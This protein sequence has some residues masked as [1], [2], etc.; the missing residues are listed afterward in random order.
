M[1]I[2]TR[3]PS[4]PTPKPAPAASRIEAAR[5]KLSPV[6][7]TPT[8]PAGPIGEPAHY[9]DVPFALR[10]IAEGS[11]AYWDK[12]A[13]T[14][15]YYGWELP[16]ELEPYRSEL[17]SWE[18]LRED[19][20]NIERG[21]V[22]SELKVRPPDKEIT[23]RPHQLEGARAIYRAMKAG[24][25]GFL[26]ADDVGLGKTIETWKAI[27]HSEADTVLVVCPLAVIA[28][29]RRTIRW[30]GDGGKRVV[31]INYD[32]LKKLFEVPAQI[33]G[34]TTRMRKGRKVRTQKGIAKFGDVYEFDLVVWDESHRL[35][36]IASARA[37]L[38]ARIDAEADF[39]IW[40]SATAGQNPLE[41]AYLAP[42]LAES[43]GAKVRDLADYEKWCQSQGIGVMRGAFGKWTWRGNSEEP[44]ER[45][46]SDEDLDKV[47]EI[48]FG[49]ALPV[50]IRR[51]PTDI[52]GWPEINRILLP[53][54]L[55]G[56]DRLLYEQAWNEFRGALDLER[57]G[58]ADSKNAL[59]IRLRF[60]QKASLLRTG[61]TVDHAEELLSQGLQVAVSVAFRETLDIIREA[62]AKSGHAVSVIHG[63]LSAGERET[64]RL[65]FQNGRTQACI[66]TVEEGISLHQGEYNDVPRACVIHDVRWSA[67]QMKQ[68]EGRTHRDGKF[69]QVYWMVGDGTVEERLAS[70]VGRRVRSMSRM[71]GDTGT[72]REIESLL[73]AL[74]SGSSRKD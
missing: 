22:E 6:A 33:A 67:I 12:V 17:Y 10:G 42:L 31:V 44:T 27:L 2:A 43:T 28:H 71:Q 63:G 21:H 53:V 47:R 40:L 13:K 45:A 20:R 46:G 56:E 35:R 65:D 72:E 59:V 7:A 64:Q 58:S 32:R 34:K 73:M 1:P 37:K 36:N 62:L 48:L 54:T 49:G 4:K 55:E 74:A 61:F 60:R 70:V 5:A 26:V 23:L 41:L 69:S 3:R 11:G 15:V 18:R 25:T 14:Y 19:E 66:F 24:R 39:R 9:L 30:M 50:G 29:W 57:S 68:I 52:A 38:S 16:W 8:K 51:S